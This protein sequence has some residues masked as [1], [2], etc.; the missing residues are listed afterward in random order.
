[1]VSNFGG[2]E[3][4]AHGIDDEAMHD[5]LQMHIIATRQIEDLKMGFDIRAFHA[6]LS[7]QERKALGILAV[8]A[9]HCSEIDYCGSY[10]ILSLVR[11][12]DGHAKIC[13]DAEQCHALIKE[14]QTYETDEDKIKA[15]LHRMQASPWVSSHKATNKP[16]LGFATHAYE[17]KIK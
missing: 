7:K 17:A 3:M 1:M 16:F 12:S 13:D 5:A 10:T 4:P 9:T 14:L 15:C 11:Y 2:D 8:T 6:A